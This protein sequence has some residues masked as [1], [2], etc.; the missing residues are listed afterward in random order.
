MKILISYYLPSGGMETLNRLRAEALSKHRVNCYFHY[1]WPGNGVQNINGL[2]ICISDHDGEI[3]HLLHTEQFDAVI[4]SHNYMTLERIRSLG[5][6]GPI[7]FEVQGLGQRHDAV[8][9]L[10]EAAP[11]I[12][13][14]SNGVL[15][16]VTSHLIELFRGMFP[17]VGQFCF[18]NLLDTERF[19]YRSLPVHPYPIVG[20]VGRIETNKNWRAF[21]QIGYE[22]RKIFPNLQLWLFEDATLRKQEEQDAFNHMIVSQDMGSYLFRL[23][24]VPHQ[25]MAEYYSRIGDAGGFL[26]STSILEGFGY[27]VSEA[28]LCRCPVLSTDSDGVRS[29]IVHNQTG[30][31]YPQ[32]RIDIAALEAVDLINNHP[33]REQIRNNGEEHI[34]SNFSADLYCNQFLE[35]MHSLGVH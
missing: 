13:S 33:L 26:A 19:G 12:R 3:Q 4:V 1:L 8:Q 27:A 29:F 20:W 28:M 6:R 14:Y 31:F 18:H 34:K 32:G 11:F 15:Y 30:K 9:T 24:N 10:M 7:L 5:F 23:S 25:E 16:P 35:M 2:P 22:L 21:L 17:D